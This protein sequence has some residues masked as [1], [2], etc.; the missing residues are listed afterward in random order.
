LGP[1]DDVGLEVDSAEVLVFAA[2]GA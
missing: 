1:G 2:S